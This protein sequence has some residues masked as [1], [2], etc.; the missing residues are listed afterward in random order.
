M[1]QVDPVVGWGRGVKFQDRGID[2]V[3][4]ARVDDP[5]RQPVVFFRVLT[6][7]YIVPNPENNT[8]D[9]GGKGDILV[10][11]VVVVIASTKPGGIVPTVRPHRQVRARENDAVRRYFC[12]TRVIALE[13]GVDQVL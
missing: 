3:F 9:G 13:I 5:H 6:G 4:V 2:L 12:P 1:I 10:E 11:P 7:A 8:A